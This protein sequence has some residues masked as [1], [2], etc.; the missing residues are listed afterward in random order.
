MRLVAQWRRIESELPADWDDARLSL[1]VRD[2]TKLTRAA[3]LLGPANP[4]RRNGGLLF[5]VSR[6][7]A[8]AGPEA[9]RRLLGRLDG[10]RIPATLTLVSASVQPVREP[11]LATTLAA[12]WETALATLPSD[13]SDLLCELEVVSSDYLQRTALLLS[14]LNPTRDPDKVAF[15]FRVARR[16]G[17]G[18]SPQM[19][20][21][22]LE[23]VDEEGV[24]G[25][26]AI[27]R[28]LSDTHNVAT[29]GP[30]W[31]VGGKPV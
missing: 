4:G 26:V 19:V 21:R 13:W 22:C 24:R 14:P 3:A 6:S 8:A 5:A 15:R 17:Y 12:A 2:E 16:F 9:V 11:E 31:Y 10:E 29:Q 27:L 7:G 23:R 18:A 25:R 1:E 20:R 30:V 28:A